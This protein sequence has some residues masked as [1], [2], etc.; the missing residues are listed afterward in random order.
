M[1][2]ILP[3]GKEKT[4]TAEI[5]DKNI[6]YVI[7]RGD[8]LA[9]KNAKEEIRKWIRNPIGSSSISEMV[10]PGD[11]VVIIGDD[12]TR[13]TPQDKII[14]VLLNELGAVGVSDK[15]IE[16][17]VALGTHRYM[18]EREIRE[19]YGEE[20]T[21]RVNVINHDYKDLKKLVDMGKTESGIPVSVNKKVYEADHVIGVGNIVP[22]CYAGWAGGGKIIQPGVSGEETTAMTHIMAGKIRPV[23]KILGKLD[24]RVKEEIDAVALKAGLNFII[25]TVLNQED[26]IAH[27]V[28]G[29]PVKAFREG[30]KVAEK[31]YCQAVPGK[32]DIV[33][34]SSYP[35]DID[36]WQALKPLDYAS[37][38]VKKGGTII[39]VTPCPDRISPMHPIFRE[40]ATLG[41]YENLKAIESRE[42]EDLVAA[43]A[44]L[45]HAQILEVAEVICYSDGLTEDDKMALGFQHASNIDEALEIAFKRQG[46]EAE[47]GVLKCG[48]ILPILQ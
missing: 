43:G 28:A 35:A 27:V 7:G 19:K 22:H 45:A 38:A 34:V 21:E 13:P 41:Y 12:I 31:V 33:I 6:S 23:S 10:K 39:L 3:Y 15:K 46:G 11:N 42:L 30:V 29:D 16:V 5:P 48:E 4:V 9:L 44:L 32:A 1:Q 37:V 25:N 26:K 18:T 14:P 20:V 36:Y 24:H 47:V 40:R 2:V 8:I 17:I